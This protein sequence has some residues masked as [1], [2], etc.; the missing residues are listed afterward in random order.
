MGET[1][2][3]SPWTVRP[4]GDCEAGSPV[5]RAGNRLNGQA[6]PHGAVSLDGVAFVG[7]AMPGQRY[8]W[9]RKPVLSRLEA[10]TALAG[11]RTRSGCDR[12]P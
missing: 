8:T 10:Q 2:G 5:G 12:T 9:H 7:L 4:Q 3:R 11:D 6:K 1:G